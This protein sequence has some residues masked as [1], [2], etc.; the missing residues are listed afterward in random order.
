[1]EALLC[2]LIMWQYLSIASSNEGQGDYCK[3]DHLVGLTGSAIMVINIV[4]TVAFET[5]FL[6]CR[7]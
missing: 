7:Q 6:D 2:C 3:D 1:M 5:S 4:G